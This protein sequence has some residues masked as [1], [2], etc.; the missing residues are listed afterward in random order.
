MLLLRTSLPTSPLP[1]VEE[2]G[3]SSRPP[4]QIMIPPTRNE[5]QD[6][7]QQQQQQSSPPKKTRSFVSS[8]PFRKVIWCILL[9][10]TFFELFR[11]LGKNNA[12]SNS[13]FLSRNNVDSMLPKPPYTPGAFIHV[14]KTGGSTLCSQ[15]RNACHSWWPKPCNSNVS[16]VNES[17]LSFLTTYYHTPDFQ[18][19]STRQYHYDF[20]VWTLRDPFS[21]LLSAFTY[22]HPLN[23]RYAKDEKYWAKHVRANKPV[24]S[25]FPTLVRERENERYHDEKEVLRKCMYIVVYALTKT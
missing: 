23:M 5:K 19:L 12:A 3:S 25:C 20:Y 13:S 24:F 14:G 6:Q 16:I 22:Q 21:R 9:I 8:P 11:N 15:L 18:L 2:T 1:P 10:L 4:L 17:N 7:Q